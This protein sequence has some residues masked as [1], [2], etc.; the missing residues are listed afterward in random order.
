[1]RDWQVSYEAYA[2]VFPPPPATWNHE[3]W[4]AAAE[5]SR[6]A[7]KRHLDAYVE[8]I[9]NDPHL[10]MVPG[11]NSMSANAAGIRY[12]E[13]MKKNG[14]VSIDTTQ[15]AHCPWLGTVCP[16]PDRVWA[17]KRP[18][19]GYLHATWRNP[20]RVRPLFAEMDVPEH[21]VKSEMCCVEGMMRRKARMKKQGWEVEIRLDER[22][23]VT[24]EY[25]SFFGERPCWKKGARRG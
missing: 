21:E 23:D 22:P 10:F 9:D 18:H 7:M 5:R 20:A 3:A 1:M 2:S 12:Y 13:Q 15:P 25:E 8:Q 6:Q 14:R 24:A 11:Q 19:V 17:S 16:H 4:T